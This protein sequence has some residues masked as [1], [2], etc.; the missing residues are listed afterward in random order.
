MP[1]AAR[2][3]GV[4]TV[5]SLTGSGF[6]CASPL[7]TATDVCSENVFVNGIGSVRKDDRIK[8]HPKPGCSTD[9]S[10]VT[11]YSSSVFINN[12]N[13]ARKGDNYTSDN[14]ISSGSSDVFIGG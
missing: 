5:N 1:E 2:G 11:T 3:D 12:K 7:V 4:D 8:A 13:A 6:N 10:V 9:T 14:T